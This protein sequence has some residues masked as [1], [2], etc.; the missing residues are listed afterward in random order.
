LGGVNVPGEEHEIMAAALE[1]EAAL[2]ERG[3]VREIGENYDP[4]YGRILEINADYDESVAFAFTFWDNWVD[5]SN[6]EWQYH[7]PIAEREW[8]VSLAKSPRRCVEV[9]FLATTSSSS[10]FDSSRDALS[11]N[12]SSRCSG[13]A[14]QQAAEAE[15]R[16]L[17]QCGWPFSTRMVVASRAAAA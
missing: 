7:D 5:A 15:G 14:A 2:Q 4:T 11:R 3:S 12:G 10:R 17:Q 16:G 9:N 13:H 8:R 1:A 6:H